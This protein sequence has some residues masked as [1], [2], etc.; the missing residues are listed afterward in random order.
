MSEMRNFLFDKTAH[1]LAIGLVLT[2]VEWTGHPRASR[3]A[4][5][6]TRSMA[7]IS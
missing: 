2:G 7:V 6:L 4:A 1:H 5:P 3:F